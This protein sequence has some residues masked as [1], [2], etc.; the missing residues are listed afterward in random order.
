LTESIPPAGPKELRGFGN[1]FGGVALIFASVL[2]W[3]GR[4][5]APYFLAASVAFFVIAQFVPSLLKPLYGPWMRF[6]EFLAPITTRILL[7]VFYYVGVTPTGLLMRLSG[8]DPM[9]RRFKDL[10][11]K[12][13]WNQATPP[14]QGARHFDNQF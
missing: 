2:W 5:A 14:H 7:T 11:A 8:K 10:S 13:Y 1:V 3:R 6:A 9:Q 4:P 12:T